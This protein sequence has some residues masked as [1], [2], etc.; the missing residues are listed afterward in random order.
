MQQRYPAVLSFLFI[1]LFISLV[2]QLHAQRSGKHQGIPKT[3]LKYDTLVLA[4]GVYFINPYEYCII[5]KDTTI[6]LACFR[7]LSV[8]EANKLRSESF[9]DSIYAK[10]GANQ[11]TSL[12]YDIAFVSP[13]VSTLPD[14]VQTQKIEIPFLP[15][16][17]KVIR[18]VRIKTLDPF[19][20]TIFDTTGQADT[21]LG[22][23]GNKLHITTRKM[24]I[25]KNLMFKPGQ[26]VDPAKIAD[27]Q[28]ILKDL[29]YIDDA[30]IV[31]TETSP[32]SDTVDVTVIAKDVF[33]VGVTLTILDPIN[34]RGTIYD[35]NLLGTGDQ[36]GIHL[37]VKEARAPFFKFDGFSF[38][39]TNIGG[40]FLNGQIYFTRDDG[41]NQQWFLGITRPF[42]SY[43]V[44]VAGGLNFSLQTTVNPVNDTVTNVGKFHQEYGWIGYS[45]RLSD[46]DSITRIVFTEGVYNRY[47][48]TRPI[49]TIDS[50]SG[51]YN[52]TYFLTGIALSKN[53]YYNADYIN[54]FGKTELLPYGHLYQL[55][56]GPVITE[57]YTRF[58][59][60]MDLSAG[61]FIKKFGGLY[62]HINL[63]GYLNKDHL[64]DCLLKIKLGYMTRLYLSK[65]K[66]YKFR[67]FL[68]LQYIYGFNERSNNE[69]Y[70]D[71]STEMGIPHINIDS[72]FRGINQLGF[73]LSS[74]AYTPWYF[75]GFRFAL[76]ASVQGGLVAGQGQP[77]YRR[78]FYCGIG[79]G[80]LI[81]ND[82]LVF[83][84]F[85]FSCFVYPT[86]PGVSWIQFNG[87]ETG[88]LGVPDFNVN[89]PVLQTMQN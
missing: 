75:Y 48:T 21:K 80:I 33:P 78:P 83:P 64:E 10:L 34:Y 46:A 69:D 37:S 76:Q 72:L 4:P 86:V 15:Y 1:L 74:I 6:I 59:M 68:N 36:F 40:S 39:L 29:P 71:L 13:K 60:D 19:G 43:S 11:F 82:N 81:K 49:V 77:L 47:Y 18:E 53:R 85:F 52:T 9:Y 26:L 3:F 32:G 55:I 24:V 17:G 5:A 79:V 30:R 84:T 42:Y 88:S 31:L 28:R 89:P 27:N 56:L 70:A 45:S 57:Y 73:N 2:H 16:A 58:Y 66:S 61:N 7:K 51:Y 54:Q 62:G 87:Y 23:F 20:P 44:K 41:G 22:A 65:S 35:R 50:N 14:T 25:R 67:S 38:N 12:L 63:G 8:E